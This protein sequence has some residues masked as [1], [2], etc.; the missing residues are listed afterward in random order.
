MLE[1]EGKK[2]RADVQRTS[3]SYCQLYLVAWEKSYREKVHLK[4]CI[5]HYSPDWRGK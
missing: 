2:K 5:S 1:K 4:T 3:H